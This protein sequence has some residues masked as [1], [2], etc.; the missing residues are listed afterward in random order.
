M[1][2]EDGKK[3]WKCCDY[4]VLAANDDD[5]DEKLLNEWKIGSFFSSQHRMRSNFNEIKNV[6]SWK[7]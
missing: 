5:N 3:M 1:Y 2:V 4:N 7:T 6:K